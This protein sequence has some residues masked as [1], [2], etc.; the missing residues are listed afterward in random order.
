MLGVEIRPVEIWTDSAYVYNGFPKYMAKWRIQTWR[1]RNK[2]VCSADLW[3]KLDAL[4]Q[5]RAFVS[6]VVTKVVAHAS[7]LDV[8][9][10]RTTAFDKWGND[11]ADA[12]AVSCAL[13]HPARVDREKH[14]NTLRV[15]I[16]EQSKR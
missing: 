15:V 12:L 8:L 14:F 10:G 5:Q 1:K 7:A 3:R 16:D 4:L 13:I 9:K 2:L 11:H 6:G